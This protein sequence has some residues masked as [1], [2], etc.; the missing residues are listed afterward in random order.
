MIQS[1]S[2][3]IRY[4]EADAQALGR[5][6]RYGFLDWLLDPIWTYQR[7]MRKL[8]YLSNVKCAHGGGLFWNFIRRV[9]WI[10][11]Q[12]LG[13]RLGFSIEE[14]SFEEG[15]AIWH[16]GTIVVNGAARIGRNAQLSVGVNIG[17]DLND[18]CPKIGDNLWTGPGAKLFG[19]IVLGDN[20]KVG[21]NAVVNKSFP[22][23]NCTLVGIPAH[24]VEK[25]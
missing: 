24:K 2:D 16:W 4:L 23:G 8:A 3:L 1:K 17:K 15:L 12:R 9:T 11:Y 25:R 14:N 18:Q 21:A 10:R 13:Q 7:L 20:V 22:E 5:G 19:G 6:H